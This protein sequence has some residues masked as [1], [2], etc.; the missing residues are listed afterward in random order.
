M[1][2]SEMKACEVEGGVPGLSSWF[3]GNRLLPF[4]NSAESVKIKKPKR[5]ARVQ[6]AGLG[7]VSG[8]CVT[9]L[10]LSP[11]LLTRSLSLQ[12]GPRPPTYFVIGCPKQ[13]PARDVEKPLVS[14]G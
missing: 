14:A 11:P 12:P 13:I 1:R 8:A 6:A 9:E 5:P 10:G 4:L 3:A 2:R 7:T